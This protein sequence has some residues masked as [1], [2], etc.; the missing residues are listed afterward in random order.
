MSWYESNLTFE[1]F[2]LGQKKKLTKI[3]LNWPKTHKNSHFN[4]FLSRKMDENFG[5]SNSYFTHMNSPWLIYIQNTLTQKTQQ[6]KTRNCWRK[7]WRWVTQSFWVT[8]FANKKLL[9]FKFDSK[10]FKINSEF[11]SFFHREIFFANS[12]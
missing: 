8:W 1:F 6:F 12:T 10:Q 5:Y 7:C 4:T 2:F 3:E 11:V 9:K